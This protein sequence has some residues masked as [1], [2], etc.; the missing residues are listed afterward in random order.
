VTRRPRSKAARAPFVAWDTE[1]LGRGGRHRCVLLT[2]DAGAVAVD[3]AGLSTRRLLGALWRGLVARPDALHI[4]F[5]FGYDVQMILRDLPRA[6]AATLWTTGKCRWGPYRLTYE[7]RRT[8]SVYRRQGGRWVGGR[9]WDTF[10]FFQASFVKALALYGVATDVQASIAAMKLRRAHFTRRDLPAM[11]R[12]ALDE[13][14][15]LVLLLEAVRQ[16]ATDAGLT[17]RRWDG[18]G[19]VASALLRAHDAPRYL[20]RPPVPVAGDPWPTDVRT[21]A[22]HAYFGGRIEVGRVGHTAGPVVRYDVRSAYPAILATLPD[23]RGWWREVPSPA[24]LTVGGTAAPS[25]HWVEWNFTPGARWYPFPWRA[26]DGAVLY[27]HRGA[28][29]YWSPEVAAA[30]SAWMDRTLRGTLALGR[31]FTYVPEDPTSSPWG[32]IPDLY[33][34]RAQLKR[35][36]RGEEKIL[37]LGMNSLYGKLAQSLGGTVDACPRWHCLEWAGYITA[38]IRAK[39]YTAAVAAGP[40]AIALATD[41]IFTTGR[42]PALDQDAGDAL[43][44]WERTRYRSGSWVQSGVYWVGTGGDEAAYHRG[45]SAQQLHRADVL[46][47]WRRGQAQLP[48]L[49]ERFQALGAS[50]GSVSQYARRGQWTTAARVLALAPYSGQKRLVPL[51]TRPRQLAAGLTWTVPRAPLAVE[52][53]DP[54]R[55]H[56]SAPVALPW[57]PDGIPPADTAAATEFDPED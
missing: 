44:Q 17:L 19:A 7:P 50:V 35:E 20:P 8:F 13:C 55:P 41:A 42:V 11:T 27:P 9:V 46:K 40:R 32:W 1:G 39:L 25:L 43:G 45:F 4:A 28:G 31:T 33:A 34:Q 36:G 16:A 52:G 14:R 56:L 37:K 57:A 29:W 21:G 2:T 53:Y 23:G 51:A 48:V 38:A 54:H 26:R 18:A 15:A 49:E 30:A 3:P 12:Y 10:G 5:A 22:R 24:G 6:T 47:A